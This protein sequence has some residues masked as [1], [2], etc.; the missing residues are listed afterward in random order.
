MV[1]GGFRVQAAGPLGL[2]LEGGL[3]YQGGFGV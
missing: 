2:W 3:G 1:F